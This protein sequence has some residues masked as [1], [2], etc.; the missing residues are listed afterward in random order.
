MVF[1]P[2]CSVCRWPE[3]F[4]MEHDYRAQAAPQRVSAW[5]Q[6]TSVDLRVEREAHVWIRIVLH[7]RRDVTEVQEVTFKHPGTDITRTWTERPGA[8]ADTFTHDRSEQILE[9]IGSRTDPIQFAGLETGILRVGQ[10]LVWKPQST[11]L[12]VISACRLPIVHIAERHRK[13]G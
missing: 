2:N 13:D 9:I 4:P 3:D 11:Q 5:R 10:F 7:G 6:V 8:E 1:N 12:S